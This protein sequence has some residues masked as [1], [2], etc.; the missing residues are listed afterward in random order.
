MKVSVKIVVSTIC[1]TTWH[2]GVWLQLVFLFRW[3]LMSLSLT[4][5][6]KIQL[7]YVRSA[8]ATAKLQCGRHN[9]VLEDM[10]MDFFFF[11]FS[12]LLFSPAPD[13]SQFPPDANVCDN[14]L[15]GQKCIY[16]CILQGRFCL[17]LLQVFPALVKSLM[18]FQFCSWLIKLLSIHHCKTDYQDVVFRCYP[19]W[20]TFLEIDAHSF[21]WLPQMISAIY[22]DLLLF[23]VLTEKVLL[24]VLI[25]F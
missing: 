3:W 19:S 1:L 7:H 11:F 23:T 22:L 10:W 21:L 17:A 25:E 9:I 16:S 2:K 6:I 4:E 5:G 24:P 14:S 15:C 20:V 8:L 13:S 18:K 12:C